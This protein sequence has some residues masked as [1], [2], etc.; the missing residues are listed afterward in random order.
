MA[1]DGHPIYGPYGYVTRSCGV[2]AQMK[3]GY[4]L[5]LKTN[6]PPTSEFPE[7][8][9]VEDYTHQNLSDETV[10]DENNGRFCVTP[11]YPKGTYAYFATINTLTVDSAGPFLNFK[12]PVFPY[13]ATN[14]KEFPTNLT[15]ILH[16]TKICLI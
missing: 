5:D 8:F 16:Q 1:Y 13:L 7:G 6:R 11:E 12:R 15:L 10:L 3:S 2:V 9:F 4:K 14:L